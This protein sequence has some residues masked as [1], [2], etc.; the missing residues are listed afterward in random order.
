MDFDECVIAVG[1]TG[2]QGFQLGAA[3]AFCQGVETGDSLLDHLGIIFHLGQFDDLETV[4]IFLL[5]LD[6]GRDC[7]LEAVALAHQGLGLVRVVPE[8]GTF[9]L[10][11]QFLEFENGIIV[12][13]DASSAVPTTA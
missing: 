1:L 12:V 6:H 5:G 3:H 4:G 7:C 11:V 13:K 10:G 2:Q 9:R 8:F